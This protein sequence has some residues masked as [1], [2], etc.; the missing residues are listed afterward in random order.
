[1]S[2]LEICLFRAFPHF[3]VGLFLSLALS[4]MSSLCILEVNCLSVVSFVIIFSNSED[5]LF[6]LL[7]VSFAVHKLLNLIRSHFFTFVF[8]SI[9][10]GGE[11]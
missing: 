8:I 10:L 5:C 3:L 2:P 11:S 9:T 1:M 4:C 7:I 6:T